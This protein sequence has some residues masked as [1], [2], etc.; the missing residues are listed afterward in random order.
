MNKTVMKCLKSLKRKNW[1]R[2]NYELK[3]DILK[4]VI[5]GVCVRTDYVAAERIAKALCPP[6]GHKKRDMTSKNGEITLAIIH[7]LRA[8]EILQLEPSDDDSEFGDEVYSSQLR[9]SQ[10]DLVEEYKVEEKKSSDGE[11]LRECPLNSI[12]RTQANFLNVLL[13]NLMNVSSEI[14]G[15]V[16]DIIK[17]DNTCV[18]GF[19]RRFLEGDEIPKAMT[20]LK[21]VCDI[22]TRTWK[23]TIR[24]LLM[25][26]FE[27]QFDI[28]R[29]LSRRLVP[30][31]KSN[32]EQKKHLEGDHDLLYEDDMFRTRSFGIEK[33]SRVY[34]YYVDRRENRKR[35]SDAEIVQEIETDENGVCRVKILDKWYPRT[36][37]CVSRRSDE[38]HERR[39]SQSAYVNRVEDMF[40]ILHRQKRVEKGARLTLSSDGATPFSQANFDNTDYTTVVVQQFGMSNSQSSKECFTFVLINS[41]DS[42][43]IEW[44]HGRPIIQQLI[45][46]HNIVTFPCDGKQNHIM[47]GACAI[48]DNIAATPI[49]KAV[50]QVID[51]DTS[52]LVV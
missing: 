21:R 19:A 41:N 16:I 43:E 30:E 18:Y 3:L 33:G 48:K 45:K 37:V 5:S 14:R 34:M 17:T 8:R 7:L 9:Q 44:V 36:E 52:S 1:C 23:L 47:T 11:S 2:I 39:P 4:T 46:N 50:L 26:M 42:R 40:D 13:R 32:T 35:S 38:F 28:D 27:K 12:G 10:E 51:E 15:E 20:T 22:S 31:L 25:G 29:T 24:P 6:L 49:R